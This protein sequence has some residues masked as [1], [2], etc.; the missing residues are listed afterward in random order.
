[1]IAPGE[2]NDFI[3][4]RAGDHLFCPFECDYCTFYKLK[5]MD[6]NEDRVEDSNLL[7][8]IR[9]ANLDAFW[10]RRPSTV[11]ALRRLFVEQVEAGEYFGFQM[12]PPLGPFEPGYDSG[13]R[14][15]PEVVDSREG[16][17]GPHQ[18]VSN[19]SRQH[20]RGLGVALGE[21]SIRSYLGSNRF[22]LVLA[23]YDRGAGPSG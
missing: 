5:G 17:C 13:M 20:T 4:A 22:G 7:S 12:F 14:A 2:E 6:A 18:R 8:Y 16:S 19:G 3:Y 21:G 11:N 15:A 9:R 23:F 1:M 10:S